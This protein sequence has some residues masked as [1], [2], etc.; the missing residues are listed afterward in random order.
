[1]A[2]N[3]KKIIAVDV[4][5]SVVKTV[6]LKRTNAGYE[7]SKVGWADV[8]FTR[9]GENKI[10]LNEACSEAVRRAIKHAG[11]TYS[12][13][14]SSLNSDTAVVRFIQL[15]EMPPDELKSALQWEAQNILPFP[16]EEVSIDYKTLRTLSDSSANS[17]KLEVL[18]VAAKKT[19]V[20]EHEKL[21]KAAQLTPVSIDIDTFALLRSYCVSNGAHLN[22]N[23]TIA[24]LNLGASQT[25]LVITREGQPRFVRDI[26]ISGNTITEVIAQRLNCSFQRAEQLKSQYSLVETSSTDSPESINGEQS[27]LLLSTLQGS[28]EKRLNDDHS[29][30]A[31]PDIVVDAVVRQILGNLCKEVVKTLTFYENM[32]KPDE[33]NKVVRLVLAGGC[34]QLDG[35]LALFEKETGLPCVLFNPL[36]NIKVNINDAAKAAM[37]EKMSISLGVAIGLGIQIYDNQDL[38][39]SINII[40]QTEKKKAAVRSLNLGDIGHI[41]YIAICCMAFLILVAL[42]GLY[43]TYSKWNASVAERKEATE[44]LEKN[45]TTLARVQKTLTDTMAINEEIEDKFAVISAL[46]PPERI[47]W[48]EKLN[49]LAK[50]R[51]G[52]SVFLDRIELSEKSESVETED[53]KRRQTAWLARKTAFEKDPKNEKKRFNEPQPVKMEMPLITYTLTLHGVASGTDSSERLTQINNYAESLAGLKWIRANGEEVSFMDGFLPEYRFLEQKTSEVGGVTVMSFGLA[54]DSKMPETSASLIKV[55]DL[56]TSDI[57][58]LKIDKTV[59]EAK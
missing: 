38:N 44:R 25:N 54:F 26:A 1:M 10:S 57:D 30:Q 33:H 13:V 45:K 32:D 20:A 7:L 12:Y 41:F 43:Y 35:L 39:K 31:S 56:L 46:A 23:E 28:V 3:P 5:S 59:G 55:T 27:T 51:V 29:Q 4:G 6:Q 24:I 37:L 21:L 11:I 34:A 9:D 53:S 15:P 22:K 19:D 2:L 50:A 40:S 42:G 18:V 58:A 52:A 47:Y 48:S 36:A 49:M 16:V 14:A 8:V 17:N